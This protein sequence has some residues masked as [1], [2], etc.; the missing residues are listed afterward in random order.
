[1]F[2]HKIKWL[3]LLFITITPIIGKGETIVSKLT[4]D[5]NPPNKGNFALPTSQQ[6]GPFFSFGQ[7][8][9]EK[10]QVQFYIAPSYL[11]VEDGHFLTIFSSAVYGLTDKS[12][13]LMTVPVA[14]EYKIGM[15]QS[16]GL[17]DIYF[18]GEYA[19]YNASSSKYADQ[20]TI[21]GGLTAPTGSYYTSPSTG[22]GAMSF[23]LALHIT[24]CLWIG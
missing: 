6:P 17:G 15:T 21:I 16:H 22:L 5:D 13:L 9:I 10:N 20:M 3:V 24:G 19:F 1:M 18:Q 2:R 12:S 8:L 11:K 7:S 14:A 4:S 23:F